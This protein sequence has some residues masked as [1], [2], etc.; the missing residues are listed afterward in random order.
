[1]RNYVATH[2]VLLTLFYCNK[3]DYDELYKIQMLQK[4]CLLCDCMYPRD[5]KDFMSHYTV[6]VIMIMI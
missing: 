1:M 2:Q 6:R 4:S 5:G 3:L